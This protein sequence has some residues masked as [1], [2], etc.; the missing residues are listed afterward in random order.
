M[1]LFLIVMRNFSL[2]LILLSHVVYAGSWP[3]VTSI[4]IQQT[5]GSEWNYYF[6]Q[7]LME[8][9][10]SVD[11]TDPNKIISLGH[12]HEPDGV[13]QW[14]DIQDSAPLNNSITVSEA[15]V[16]FYNQVGKNIT[17]VTHEGN[18]PGDKECVGYAVSDNTIYPPF[19]SVWL[20][21][22]C[23][24]IPPVEQLCKITTP[25]LLLD[26]KTISLQQTE[27]DSASDIMTVNCTQPMSY[28]FNLITNDKYIYLQPSGKAEIKV[29]NQ[30][31][32]T[33]INLPQG[34]SSLTVSDMLSGVSTEGVN[35]G[36]SVLI[37]QPY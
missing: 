31:L 12:R 9:G 7:E 28:T 20:P 16:N 29:G 2:S 14:H 6:T 32:G 8:I 18:V 4:N 30:P 19:G 13:D 36:S 26:H 33:S 21:G 23:L 11:V 3:V 35:S 25:Q 34:Q 1:R 10:P 22:G 27:G 37:M 17:Y 24:I 5:G 15:G